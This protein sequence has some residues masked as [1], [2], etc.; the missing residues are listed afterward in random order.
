MALKV[1][2]DFSPPFSLYSF[3][4]AAAAAVG[5]NTLKDKYE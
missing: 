4:F 3:T 5:L 1:G 2:H